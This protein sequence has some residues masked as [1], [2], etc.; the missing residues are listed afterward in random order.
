MLRLRRD[1]RSPIISAPLSMTLARR[2]QEQPQCE[3]L[4]NTAPFDEEHDNRRDRGRRSAISAKRRAELNKKL[5][6]AGKTQ[7]TGGY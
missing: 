1:D 4:E 7:L 5:K 2:I 6:D 3:P